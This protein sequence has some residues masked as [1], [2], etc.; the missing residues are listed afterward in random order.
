MQTNGALSAQS[1]GRGE[2]ADGEQSNDDISY[3]GKHVNLYRTIRASGPEID[4]FLER[5]GL[6][7]GVLGR[8]KAGLP[9][10]CDVHGVFMTK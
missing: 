4:T 5:G 2:Q 1:H 3:D 6:Y 10:C 9:D 7:A 8:V